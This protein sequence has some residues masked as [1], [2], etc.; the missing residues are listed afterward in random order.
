GAEVADARLDVHPS[1]RLDDEQAVVP[2]RPGDERA[3]RH[4][5]AAHLRALPLAAGGGALAP[6]EH[7]RPAIERLLDERARRMRALSARAG[8][9]EHR[10]AL[11]RVHAVNRDLVDAEPARR[12]REN[13]FHEHDALQAA[14]L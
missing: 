14:R 4:A 10:L 7:L 8:G 3:R 5:V 13:R 2:G 9:A 11:G 12:L 6:P 1:V